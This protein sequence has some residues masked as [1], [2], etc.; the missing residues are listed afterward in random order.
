[1][2]NTSSPPTDKR[3]SAQVHDGGR[4]VGFHQCHSKGKLLHKGEPYCATH[5]PP[6]VAARQAAREAEWD[7][8]W[9]EKEARWS[10]EE[11]QEVLRAAAPDMLAALEQVG[12]AMESLMDELG[13]R[14][15]TNWGIVNTCLC[16]VAAAIAKARGKVGA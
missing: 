15:A 12:P 8:E 3:C 11:K 4:S 9:A 16:D 7:R 1:M 13:G 6:N 14:R 5:Y 2:T 10:E